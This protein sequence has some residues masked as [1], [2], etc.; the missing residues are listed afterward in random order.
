M[1]TTLS[2]SE[3]L[4][5]LNDP[6]IILVDVR[7]MAA[8]NG[9]QMQGEAR[10]GHIPRAVAFPLHWTSSFRRAELET[11][12]ESKGLSPE[13]TVVVY[14]YTAAES[15]AMVKVLSD[16]GYPNLLIYGAGLVEWAADDTLPVVRL[17]NYE[18]LVYP[19]WL[20]KKLSETHSAEAPDKS[21]AVF[22]VDFEGFEDYSR[23]HITNAIYLDVSRLELASSGN[24]RSD[25]DLETALLSLGIRHDT[26]VVLYGQDTEVGP[27]KIRPGVL[28]AARAAVILMYVGVKD[29]RILDGGLDTWIA[30]G[31]GLETKVHEPAPAVSFGAVIPGNPG[32]I[33]DI[34]E[35]KK[36]LADPNSVLVSVRSWQEF[37][38]QS[39]GYDYIG[40]IGRIAGAVWGNSGSDANHMENYRNPDNSMRVYHEIEE[41]W[42]AAGI[43]P[44]KQI[45][46]YCGT[47]WRASEAFFD[48]YLL[49][50]E[51]VAV[52]DGGWFEWSQDKSN[53]T[54]KG[55]PGE[56][57]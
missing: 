43:T 47:G 33:I 27:G 57:P 42:R 5:K 31:Y 11:L 7:P 32:Y 51:Q 45:G 16:V 52:Y 3:L 26:R 15:A 36:L 14:G 41:N 37:T 56:R 17:P 54:E 53:P 39:S 55:I 48:A 24:I 40:P 46:F 6:G 10:G 9:W 2:K 35:A 1:A 30:S 19:E 21:L 44:D 38:G 13:K 29:V 50:W 49:G 8:Y 18:K 4:E 28:A 34:E 12:F 20:H 23:G 25:D 22:H